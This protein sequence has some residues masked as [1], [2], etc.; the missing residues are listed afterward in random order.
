M[1]RMANTI[2]TRIHDYLKDY[3]PFSLLDPHQ[4]AEL[5]ASV[6]VQYCR[7]NEVIFRQGEKPEQRIFVVREGA[8]QMVR[9]EDDREILVVQIGRAHV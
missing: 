6:T 7:P 5:S 2:S 1:I 4:L 3:P 8:V 9:Q